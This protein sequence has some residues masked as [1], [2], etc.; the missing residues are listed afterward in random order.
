M[1]P[2]SEIP[3][4]ISVLLVTYVFIHPYLNLSFELNKMIGGS[5]EPLSTDVTHIIRE[6]E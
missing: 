5:W 6:S 1:Q 3:I 2:K 4:E